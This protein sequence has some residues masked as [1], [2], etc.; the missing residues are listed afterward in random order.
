MN[1]NNKSNALNNNNINNNEN[2][3]EDEEIIIQKSQL[4]GIQN[5]F[6]IFIIFILGI[7]WNDTKLYS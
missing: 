4:E 5:V 3:N 7:M 1:I 6:L 2:E